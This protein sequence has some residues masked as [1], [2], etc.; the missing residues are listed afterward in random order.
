MEN[1]PTAVRRRLPDGEMQTGYS[2]QEDSKQT[3]I[4]HGTLS[5]IGGAAGRIITALV[6][7][8]SFVVSNPVMSGSL[9]GAGL[10]LGLAIS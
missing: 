4:L 6:D 10:V 2:T 3:G 8:V 9:I 5:G 7:T 1:H